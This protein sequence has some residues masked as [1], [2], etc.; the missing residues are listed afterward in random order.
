MVVAE[1]QAAETLECQFSD[2]WLGCYQKYYGYVSDGTGELCP[3]DS[4]ENEYANTFALIAAL[5]AAATACVDPVEEDWRC[6]LS[7]EPEAKLKACR[8]AAEAAKVAQ[9]TCSPP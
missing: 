5:D 2:S 8:D 1:A 3:T 4:E 6:N 7:G 9:V